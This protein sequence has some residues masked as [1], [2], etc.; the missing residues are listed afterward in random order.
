MRIATPLHN[1]SSGRLSVKGTIS[2]RVPRVTTQV[3]F[4]VLISPLR[5]LP[6]S[7]PVT[8]RNE[9]V[10][11]VEELRMSEKSQSAFAKGTQLLQRGDVE[12]S[13]TYFKRALAKEPGYYQAY[14]NLGL[15]HYRLGET[16]QAEEDFQKSIDLANGGFAPSLFALAMILCE[17]R[18]FQRAEK[19]IESGLVMDPGSA[20]GKYFQGLVQFALN[21]NGEAEKSAHDAL[22][23]SASQA[24]AYVLL[25]KIHNRNHNPEAVMADVA[26]YLK[27]EP[28]GLLKNEA[29]QLLLQ[30]Q[31]ELRQPVAP[32]H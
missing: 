17:K 2:M 10:V 21:R 24:D 28:H 8:P 18:E 32:S 11:S 29:R 4:L 19:L 12:R 23:R 7:H 27:L 5:C 1:E 30:A 15:A 25:A 6:Q 3:M 22:W 26:S 16:T 14:H 13:V 20:V 9:S 31:Q